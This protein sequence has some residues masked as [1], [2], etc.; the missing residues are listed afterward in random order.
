MAGRIPQSF[1]DELLNRTDI[2]EVIDTRVPLKKAGREY[3]ACCPFHNEK[4]P[5]FTVSQVKQFYHCF[6]CGEHGTAITFLMAYEHMEFVEAIEEL[7]HRAGLEVPHEAGPEP[8]TSSIL[9][10]YALL[11]RVSAYYQAQL[12]EHPQAGRAI[13]YL[14]NRGLSG[15]VAARF[16][17]GFAPPG[18]ENLA[19]ALGR[20]SKVQQQLLE[21]GLTIKRDDGNGAYDRFRDRIQFPIHDRRG[22]TIGFGGRVLDDGTPK[23]LN[24]PESPVFHKGKELYG[25]FEA[26]KAV[27]N[28]ERILVV[29]GYMDVVALAQF[30]IN[31]AVATLGTATTHEHLESLFRTVPEVVFCFDG[32][33]AGREAAWR[34]LVNT[35]PV[36]RDGREARFLFLP[37][38][39]DPD[40]LVRKIGSD[41]F[42]KQVETATHLSDFFFDRLSSQVDI[43][44]IDGR[45]RLV[46]LAKP[47][48][49]S[50][51]DSVFRQLMFERL[52]ELAHTSTTRVAGPEVALPAG[53]DPGP[54]I[55]SSPA[56]RAGQKSPVRQAIELLLY[57]PALAAEVTLPASIRQ[58]SQPGVSL[59]IE[60][61]ELIQQQPEIN[62]AVLLE[63][64]RNHE[65][66]RYLSKLACWRPPL[67]DLEL[68]ADLQG[69]LNEI[70]R[71]HIENRIN[72][73]DSEHK[74]RALSNAEKQEYGKLLL[75]SHAARQH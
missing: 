25:L 29:E 15:D 19:A 71:Q 27:R 10:H 5:S 30:D 4:T 42:E 32:D 73:L 44:S 53:P 67:D 36:L 48:L 46:T 23:Y 59:L 1:I 31:Y 56:R 22:R 14:K 35:L 9:P 57:K 37:D 68:A 65:D 50:L 6:G 45:A 62:T 34:A 66:G 24:S 7:A 61:I 49:A 20:D 63:H 2:V 69:N 40:S 17:I 16:Q 11:D 72:Y 75:Q 55:K 52:A 60:I 54:S 64:W 43:S 51:P 13:A 39:E 47:L 58:C 18:W 3:K 12:R 74:Q 26:R 8:H 70:E 33:R 38:D 21:L 41:A 28:L